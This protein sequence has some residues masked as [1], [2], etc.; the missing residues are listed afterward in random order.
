M[1]DIPIHEALFDR[2]DGEAPR[3]L[4]QS[5]GC[6]ADWLA[7]AEVLVVG[8]GDRPAGT[9]CAGV[10][11]AHPLGED[12]VAVVHVADQERNDAGRAV[13]AFHF[14]IIPRG[15]YERFL[16]DPFAVG[17]RLPP[18]WQARDTLPVR[19]LAAQPLPARTIHDVQQ[20]LQRVKAGAL[21][22]DGEPEAEVVRT[23]ENSESPALLGG[24]QVLV[25]GGRLFFERRH[26]DPGLIPALWMLLPSSTRCRLWPASFAFGNA[27]GFDAVVVPR[28]A[29]SEYE[30]Y[31]SE[32]QA[33]DYPPG[34]YELN[35]QIAAE[36]GDQRQLDMLLSRRSFAETWRLALTLL[37]LLLFLS[38][39]AQVLDVLGPPPTQTSEQRARCQLRR[40]SVAAWVAGLND[41]LNAMGTLPPARAAW[42]TI[43]EE[44]GP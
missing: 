28:A 42:K 39:A 25:D 7:E 27:L 9:V 6:R 29:A 32:E 21:C 20:V 13:A 31:T 37:A 12:R 16:G 19:S 23:L 33:A 3:L 38:L 14:L 15:A 30:G 17:R 5:P 35:L 41:P 1:G 43:D 36:T 4:A 8:F 26:A 34:R 24:V 22:E 11:F 44:C 2:P 10:V 40:I 18:L